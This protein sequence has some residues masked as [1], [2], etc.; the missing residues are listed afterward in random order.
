MSVE[1]PPVRKEL[2]VKSAQERAFRLFT[3]GMN[4]W[5]PREHHIGQSPLKEI[6]VEPRVGGRWYSVCEDGSECEV[7]KVLRWE[8]PERL[9]LAWQITGQWQ[10]DP[11]FS[12]EV[13]V[14]FAA[15]SPK[16]TRV[17]LEHRQLERYGEAAQ[18]IRGQ[19]DAPGGWAGNLER[20]ANT[21]AL[22]A[23]VFYEAAAD[24][25]STAPLHF[26]AHKQRLDAF[27]ARGELLAV[28]TYADPREGSLAV[29]VDRAA[30]EEFVRE[31]PFVLHGVVSKATIKDWNEV[32]ME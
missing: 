19:L 2:L 12:T 10:F 17:T 15:V 6:I 20:F 28:G 14:T 26:G 13:E 21:A 31:D 7:G 9:V 22:K 11:A 16:L 30:A 32:L 18:G 29:F 4:R 24:V 23:V 1:V 3:S 27:R 8:A 5:W 25:F